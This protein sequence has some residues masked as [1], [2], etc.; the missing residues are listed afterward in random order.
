[1][2]TQK[3]TAVKKKKDIKIS[4]GVLH[5]HTTSNNTI[6]TLSST[7]GASVI[8]AGAGT[9]WFKGSKKSTPYAAEMLTKEILKAVYQFESLLSKLKNLKMVKEEEIGS[10]VLKKWAF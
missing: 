5:V 6:V 2:A 7:D 10:K 9:Q 1:M 8:S 4:T 3:K